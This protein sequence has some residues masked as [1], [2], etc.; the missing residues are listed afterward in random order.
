[1]ELA[2]LDAKKQTTL[3]VSSLSRDSGRL[4]IVG[5]SEKFRLPIPKAQK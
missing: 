4:D 3:G 1:M 2:E 5:K